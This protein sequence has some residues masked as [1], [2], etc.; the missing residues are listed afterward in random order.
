MRIVGIYAA[1]GELPS[2]SGPQN[3]SL[4]L[5]PA[6][7]RAHQD[8]IHPAD[9][10]LLVRLRPGTPRAEADAAIRATGFDINDE[11][12]LTSGIERTIRVE[13]IALLLLGIVVAGVGLVV[14]GQMLRRQTTAED[15]AGSMFWALGCDR[16]DRLRLAL[17]RGLVVGLAGAALAL[18]VAVVMSPLFPVGIGR[19]ADPDV[20]LHA[21]AEV[22]AAGFL[23]T[24]VA[25]V[26]LSLVSAAHR[27]RADRRERRSGVPA[28]PSPLPASRPPVLV[29]MYFA[30][31]GRSRASPARASLLSLVVVVVIL[32]AT[33]VTLAS[34]DHLVG[35]R[36][37]AR[38]TW[39]AA[40]TPFPDPD[41]SYDLPRAVA[42]AR[43][44]PGVEAATSG[45]WATS[46]AG[47]AS[48]LVIDGHLVGT[49]VFGD[50]GPIQPAIQQGRAPERVGEIALGPKTL[51][52][53]GLRVGD[54]VSLS[55]D[56]GRP[57]IAGRIVGETVLVS[58]YFFDFPPGTGAATVQSTFSA[59]GAERDP[60]WN[61]VL[62]RYAAGANGHTTFNAVQEALHS[63]GEAFEA[64]D[65]HGVSGLGRIRIVPVLLLLGLLGLVAAAIAHVLLVSV[66]GHR[67]DVAVLRALG[68]TRP[69]SWTSV[70][71]H[72]AVVAVAA[73]VIG[74]PL[75]VIFGR[76]A[77]DRI[78]SNLYVVSRP[79]AP[80]A[81]LA[82]IAA[83]AGGRGPRRLARPF[84]A[85]GAPQARRR[86]AR[87]LIRGAAVSR[88][89]R[90]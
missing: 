40:I 16:S 90:W 69:Q 29:G 73:C 17:L 27:A 75:G 43:A 50:E 22:L 79:M 46:G 70:T 2:A 32:A 25:T 78:A 37:L 55:L 61:V 6:F 1:P 87:R 65:R 83:G 26:A 57:S 62:A 7:G 54:D 63:P 66:T 35:R 72:A 13:T 4:L 52:S 33:A 41:G 49:Q 36:D 3:G 9:G 11:R 76:A 31:P 10:G 5:T 19:V 67:R 15:D 88:G 44:V 21:D 38:A 71:V 86:A 34:F 56:D 59:L 42:A 64:A 28:T 84:G 45:T 89:S 51:A 8:D 53:L 74:I 82:L 12:S 14:V 68:F 77:W 20:G 18:V 39:N 85:G 24:L 30:L 23:L 80:L 58:P 81:L 60:H 48:G 47:I